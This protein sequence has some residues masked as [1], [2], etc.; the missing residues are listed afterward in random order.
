[1]MDPPLNGQ[2]TVFTLYLFAILGAALLSFVLTPLIRR[3]AIRLRLFDRP[4]A[5]KTHRGPIPALGGVA[6]W[7]TFA[8]IL[9]A[10]RFLTDFPTGTLHSLRGIL[11]GGTFLFLLGL[12]DDLRKPRGLGVGTKF[13]VQILAACF[14]I[15]FGIRLRFLDPRHFAWIVTI[16]WVV[17]VTNAFNLVDIMDGLAASQ[18]A[19]AAAGFFWIALPSEAIYVNFAA[20]ALLGSCLGFLPWNLSS[21]H[22]IFMGD[23]GALPLG[24]VL[25]AISLGTQYSD[26]SPLGVYVPLLI[27]GI[28]IY[29]TLFVM[30]LR[31][32]RG[33]SPF[34][35]SRD[36]FALRLESRGWSRRQVVAV[37]ALAAALLSGAAYWITR[38]P[39]PAALAAYTALGC[40]FMLV[41]TALSQWDMR[42]KK[43]R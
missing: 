1:M 39:V 31:M 15:T 7:I 14:L 27:L 24:F 2:P 29:D 5:I 13:T 16:V 26:V 42:R 18:A 10:L 23:S 11:W 22:K 32:G 6:I 12:V 40:V 25:A 38:L 28:P 20:A 34:K 43:R 21:K 36:H 4:N 33:E 30:G 8:V 9:G 19:I 35:G 17:G 41:S 3:L 37:A